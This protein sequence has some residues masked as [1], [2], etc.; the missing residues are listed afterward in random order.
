MEHIGTYHIKEIDFFQDATHRVKN[1]QK[2]N[3]PQPGSEPKTPPS[4]EGD[5]EELQTTQPPSEL[6]M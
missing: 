1:R 3:Q 2:T 6:I 4:R 5:V